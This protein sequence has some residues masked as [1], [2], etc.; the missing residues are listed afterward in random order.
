MSYPKEGTQDEKIP[1]V[2]SQ[3]VENNKLMVLCIYNNDHPSLQ[4]NDPTL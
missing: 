1:A 3:Q 2:M 4:W